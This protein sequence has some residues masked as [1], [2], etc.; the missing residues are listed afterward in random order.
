MAPSRSARA[1]VIGRSCQSRIVVD[2]RPSYRR[3]RSGSGDT[4]AVTSTAAT[5]LLGPG[6]RLT[7]AI[8]IGLA[9]V[10]VFVFVSTD[11]EI[12]ATIPLGVDVGIPLAATQR[13]LDGGAVYLAEA[14][15]D[16]ASVGQ[17]FLYP[18]FV[19]P[20]WAPLTVLPEVARSDRLVRRC[21]GDGRTRLPASGDPLDDR[22]AR[23]PVGADVRRHLGSQCA[24]LPVRRVRRHVLAGGEASRSPAAPTGSRCRRHGHPADRLVRRDAGE[25]QGDPAPRLARDPATRLARRH[26]GRP[27]VGDPGARHAPARR[28]PD[29]RGLV[30]AAPPGVGSHVAVDGSIAAALS[31]GRGRPDPDRRVPGPGDVDSGVRTSVRGSAC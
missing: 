21:P 24:D 15:H 19:L 16:P 3:G 26:P 28:V 20:L 23:A 11:A 6:T 2:T 14:F 30:R 22:A 5:S 18:P 27:A 12:A 8:R 31:A 10:A 17:P 9:I 4:S 29:L 7:S 1:A 25:C 13:W